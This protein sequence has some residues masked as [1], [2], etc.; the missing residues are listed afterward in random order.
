MKCERASAKQVLLANKAIDM[1][2]R[3]D[4]IASKV[5]EMDD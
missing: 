2:H 1:V 5:C 3:L 4:F